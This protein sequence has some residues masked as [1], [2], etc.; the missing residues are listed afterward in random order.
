M[1]CYIY[2]LQKVLDFF[3]DSE[4]YLRIIHRIEVDAVDAVFDKVADLIYGILYPCFEESFRIVLISADHLSEF[5]RQACSAEC[6]CS[7]DLS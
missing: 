3:V 2:F 4:C 1:H 6:H 5:R 7:L